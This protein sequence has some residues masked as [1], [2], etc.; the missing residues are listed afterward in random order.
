MPNQSE[1]KI[2]NPETPIAKTQQMNERD[3][4][5]DMLST[6][7]YLKSSYSVATNELSHD[8]LYQEI[9]SICNETETTQR[10]L[11]YLMFEKGWYGLEKEDSQKINQIYQ[12][13]SGYKTQF[14]YGQG[15]Q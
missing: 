2:Q 1:N 12:Q 14:P 7:K 9:H 5:N 13:F 3:F 4:I 8:P 10:E 6:E 15:I 11:Y